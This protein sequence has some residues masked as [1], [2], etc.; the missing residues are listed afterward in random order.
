MKRTGSPKRP[1]ILRPPATSLGEAH[2]FTLN[3]QAQPISKA[4]RKLDLFVGACVSDPDFR[5]PQSRELLAFLLLVRDE[6]ID[7][8][9][10]QWTLEDIL[11]PIEVA[12]RQHDGR[13][14]A[15]VARPGRKTALRSGLE[16]LV[17]EGLKN[18][19]I[20]DR[21]GDADA[22]SKLASKHG[23]PFE[24][25]D[26]ETSIR[27]DGCLLWY[28]VG[29]DSEN[30]QRTAVTEIQKLLSRIRTTKAA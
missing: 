2:A 25:C 12:I 30:P 11:N 21:L 22:I 20:L 6:L 16:A 19:E 24:V 14:S 1:P 18:D 15:G 26:P 27:E 3:R 23:F 10:E 17:A 28:A 5:H 13:K 29:G 4:A 8:I 7:Q 9:N